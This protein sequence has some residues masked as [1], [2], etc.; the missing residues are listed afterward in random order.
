MNFPISLKHFNLIS[1]KSVFVSWITDI[2]FIYFF[3]WVIMQGNT[4]AG[5][6]STKICNYKRTYYK[7]KCNGNIAGNEKWRQSNKN[8][9]DFF[10]FATPILS[11]PVLP[12]S[13]VSWSTLKHILVQPPWLLSTVADFFADSTASSP[14]GEMLSGALGFNNCCNS[15]QDT[16]LFL[17]LC[18]NV[19]FLHCRW[20]ANTIYVICW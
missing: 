18:G 4:T 9:R 1:V 7:S 12:V 6:F 17:Q 11:A 19:M 5:D 15:D 13:A 8:Q 16:H 3:S 10:P 2:L 20:L 14:V